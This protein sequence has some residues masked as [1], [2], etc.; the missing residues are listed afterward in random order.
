MKCGEGSPL[1]QVDMRAWRRTIAEILEALPGLR[2]HK[3]VPDERAEVI[4]VD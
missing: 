3:V 1:G 2:Y 4:V